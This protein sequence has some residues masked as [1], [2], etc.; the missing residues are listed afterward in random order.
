M[1]RSFRLGV[2]II[3]CL[4][5]WQV[6]ADTSTSAHMKIT[7]SIVGGGGLV[8]ER[9]AHLSAGESIA[10]IGIGYSS[11]S[12]LAINT[13]YTTTPDPT[14][15]LT[16]ID[17]DLNFG[18]FSPGQAT[19]LTSHFSVSNY[20][21]Y[22]YVVQVVGSPPTNGSH[23]LTA[24]T[25]PTPSQVGVEQYGINLVANTSPVNLGANPD[26][27]TSGNGA[28]VGAYAIPNNYQYV[29]GD[30]VATASKSSGLTTYTIS[31]IVNVN[32]RT[33]G[34]TYSSVQTIICTGMY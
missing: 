34:G 17:Y 32:T 9:S 1:K 33:P 2:L 12:N 22:G 31:Q 13:G 5:P 27:G 10:D 26:N 7:E 6:L 14:L 4:I 24:L 15:S 21:S 23:S 29:P 16:I 28:A 3:A 18:T 25:S 11:S 8:S 20:T 30:T 19:T